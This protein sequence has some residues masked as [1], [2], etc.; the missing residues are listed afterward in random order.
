MFGLIQKIILAVISVGI[1]LLIAFFS[2]SIFI[3]EEQKLEFSM[4]ILVDFIVSGLLSF[5]FHIK[6]LSLYGSESGNTVKFEKDRIFWIFNIIF[7]I[8]LIATAI[9]LLYDSK[10]YLSPEYR[11]NAVF[12]IYLFMI[13]VPASTG[14][15][16]LIDARFLY[17]KVKKA[18]AQKL[19][20]SIDDI[21]GTG[22]E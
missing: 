3:D 11:N 12:L 21:S 18:K 17:N 7:A 1:S 22:D 16:T 4:L 10:S 14:I 2:Y 15:W 8:S 13:I 19:I 9:F 6:T 5:V 20:D